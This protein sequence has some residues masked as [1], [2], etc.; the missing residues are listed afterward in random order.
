MVER[1]NRHRVRLPD[2]RFIGVAEWGD[3]DGLPLL[4]FRGLPGSDGGDAIPDEVPLRLKL[5]RL[6]VDRPGVGASDPLPGRRLIDWPPD[7]AALADALGL[8]RFLVLGTSG[9]GPYAAA[10]AHG[11]PDRVIAVGLVSSIAPMDRPGAAG[12]M[13]A[14]ERRAMDLAARAPW[15][16]RAIMAAVVGVERL[17]PGT[18]VGTLLRSLPACDKAVLA[19]SEVAASLVDSYRRAFLQGTRWQVLDWAII[20]EPW[21]FEP[22]GIRV[23]ARIWHGALDERAPLHHAQWLA[24]TIPGATLTVYPGEGHMIAFSRMEDVLS[25]LAESAAAAA[26]G[27]EE[28]A[29]PVRA[30]AQP[31][32]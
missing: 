19:R 23:P 15:A 28:T 12:G 31:R 13:E 26:G 2:G 27:V 16:L 9:G 21:R 5:R 25:G 3:R 32:L 29:E 4:E 7:V 6:A 18:I 24:D 17:R 14:G 8:H 11:L 20:N 1:T 10:V 30:L 22:R